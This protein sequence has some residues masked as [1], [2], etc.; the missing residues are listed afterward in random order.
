M[1]EQKLS[2]E[3]LNGAGSNRA[4]EPLEYRLLTASL[5]EPVY[6]LEQQAHAFPWSRQLFDDCLSVRQPCVVVLHQQQVVGYGVVSVVAGSAELLNLAVAPQH[7]RQGVARA[8]LQHLL[9]VLS[10]C[11]DTLYLEVRQSNAPALALYELTGF[12][13]VGTRPRYYPTAQGREDAIILA[14]SFHD[15]RALAD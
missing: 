10:P 5:L 8:L 1:T 4:G 2:P 15:Q 14:Y 6:Q 11:A 13:E 7:H 12:V 9:E 3:R